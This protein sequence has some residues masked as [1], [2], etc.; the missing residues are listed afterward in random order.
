[1]K[2][3]AIRLALVTFT[4]YSSQALAAPVL[5]AVGVDT[6]TKADWRTTTTVKPYTIG[7]NT[8]YG[9]DGYS[10]LATRPTGSSSVVSVATSEVLTGNAATTTA[11]I[12]AINDVP[13]F[14]TISAIGTGWNW[15]NSG[16]PGAT[17]DNPSLT[18]GPVVADTRLGLS[19]RSLSGSATDLFTLTF[20]ADAPDNIRI[21][22]LQEGTGG[23]ISSFSLTSG[24]ASA[25]Q[26]ITGMASNDH[27]MRYVFFD[28]QNAAN[29]TVTLS[30]TGSGG[31]NNYGI[32]GFSFDVIPEP[33]TTVLLA[34]GAVALVVTGRK[35]RRTVGDARVA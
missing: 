3:T 12:S 5:T 30:L 4:V 21:G 22:I 25:T 15:Y 14:V 11:G 29:Q 28:I 9:T 18:P 10:T 27:L 2:T 23:A 20:A 17:I 7:S 33:S 34:A 6:T 24:A 32:G 35:R 1:M 31:V 13:S 26:S 19:F 8:I 16:N